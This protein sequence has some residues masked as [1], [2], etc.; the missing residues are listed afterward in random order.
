MKLW[1]ELKNFIK[2]VDRECGY[3]CDACGKEIF[4]Y[5]L[6]RLCEECARKL[7]LNDGRTCPKCGRKTVSDGVCLTCK[8]KLPQFS[9]GFSPFEYSGSTAALI[10][11]IKNGNPTLAYFFGEEMAMCLRRRYEGLSAFL[12]DGNEI[13][14]QNKLLI[15]PVPISENGFIERGYNQS[16]EL[17]QVVY[18]AL[19]AG[20]YLAELDVEA[21]IKR[22]ETRPQK[23]LTYA[24]R[25]ENVAGAYH[26]RKRSACKD[27]VVLLI[28]DILTTGATGDECAARLYGAGAREVLFLTATSLAEQK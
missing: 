21:L 3:V 27:R 16:E 15:I 22:K 19:C 14:S 26:V 9:L 25:A 10:N 8:R 18:S 28:D 6:H 5:P 4:D 13:E 1:R 23:Q 2:K 7:S 11:R 20:G 24:E 12:P 17:A